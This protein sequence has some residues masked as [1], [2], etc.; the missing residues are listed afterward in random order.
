MDK[1]WWPFVVFIHFFASAGAQE[2]A[3]DFTATDINGNSHNL[4]ATLNQGK[5]VVVVFFSTDSPYSYAYHN[6]DDLVNLYNVHGPEGDNQ[7]EIF[8][9]EGD[10]NTN[11]NCILGQSSCT[12]PNGTF[13]NWS[14]GIDFPIISSPSLA[15]DFDIDEYPSTFVICPG[16]RIRKVRAL[17]ANALW[18][19]ASEC[20]VPSGSNNVGI[21]FFD[22]GVPYDQICG[23][24]TLKPKFQIVNLG[25]NPV[26]NPKVFV[27]FNDLYIDSFFVMGTLA[28]LEERTIQ[29][30][31]IVITNTGVLKVRVNAGPNDANPTDNIRSKEF[32]NAPLFIGNVL[33][34]RFRTDAY[35]DEFYWDI[36][37]AGTNTIV[38]QG[39]NSCVG[40]NG[41]GQ[42]LNPNCS[43]STFVFDNLSTSIATIQLPEVGCY[44]LRVVDAGGDGFDPDCASCG[45]YLYELPNSFITAPVQ[46]DTFG[47]Y[48][49]YQFG[50]GNIVS[51]TEDGIDS[52]DISDLR[53]YPNPASDMATV[54]YVAH[55]SQSAQLTVYSATGSIIFQSPFSRL[56][57]GFNTWRVDIGNFPSGIYAAILQTETGMT[58]Q[59]FVKN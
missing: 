14:A 55:A 24:T 4:Y 23:A 34:L 52:N 13:Q 59:M 43:S 50:V 51:T 31:D 30:E 16:K 18:E 48:S 20:P 2:L 11:D 1:F 12:S 40:P 39:G 15:Q 37:K 47:G 21:Y 44:E 6:T 57:T 45:Y 33:K 58:R 26:I 56:Q 32:L 17:R 28:K 46:G 35:G 49:F 53:V 9:V 5:I 29:V 36:R 22:P 7:L 8:Y 3:S 38:Q 41:G 25:T 54:Q 27:Q 10:P 42:L 19:L